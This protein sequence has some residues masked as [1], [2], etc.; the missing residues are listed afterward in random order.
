MKKTSGKQLATMLN[1][2]SSRGLEA[3]LKAQ[4]TKAIIDSMKGGKITHVELSKRSGVSR[5]SVT[6]IL[7][8]SL[9]K[10]T[11]DRLLRLLEALDLTAE[12]RIKKAA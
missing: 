9:Q 12:V 4:L 7:S 5:T 10:V 3:K 1:I 6:G 11:L 8:G 2:R